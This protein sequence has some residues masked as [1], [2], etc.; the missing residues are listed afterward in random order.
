M[1]HLFAG[2]AIM[3]LMAAIALAQSELYE[4]IG[5]PLHAPLDYSRIEAEIEANIER[6]SLERPAAATPEELRAG[7]DR[8]I[9]PVRARP[10]AD[11]FRPSFIGNF[12]DL[13]PVAPFSRRDWACGART[14]DLNTGYDHAGTDISSGPF[15]AHAMNREWVEV[16]A[17]APGVIIARNDTAPDRN[18]AGLGAQQ[19]ANYVSIL[20]DD[21]LTAYYWHLA[22]ATVTDRQIGDRVEAGDFLG[23][24]GSSGISTA[25]HL[26]FELRHPDIPGF[27][28][29]PYEGICGQGETMW[30]HQH[31]YVD[32][33]ITA[34]FTHNYTPENVSDSFCQPEYPRFR[35][36]FG[37]GD[38]VYVGLYVRDRAIGAMSSLSVQDPSGTTVFTHDFPEAT[39]FAA[40]GDYQ[41]SFVLADDATPGQWVIR[42]E[43]GLD[44]RERAFYVGGSHV[45]EARLAAAL[46]PNSRS[47]QSGHA[48][49]VFATVLNP[50]EGLARGCWI[51]PASPFAGR[52]EYRETDPVTNAVTG[53]PNALFDI[54]GGGAR[55]FVLSF[56]PNTGSEANAYDLLLRYKC[57]NS[58][59]T[60]YLSGVNTVL[61]SFGDRPT[62]D[63][64]A[65]A[66]TPSRDGILR[67]PDTDSGNAFAVAVANVGAEGEL[68]VRPAG[69]REAGTLRLRICETDPDTGAC[70]AAAGDSITRVFAADESASFAVFARGGG[71]AVPFAPASNR[72]QLIAT[73]E[74]GVIRGSTS[75]AVRTD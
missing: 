29:D 57:D 60:A 26:H 10:N 70:L 68:M 50:S 1:V 45:A 65:I 67:L 74:N 54:A 41:T 69:L 66:L 31:N 3:P 64:V 7:F 6:L 42:A 32:P 38:R 39:T 28:V 56:T 13:D 49:T 72:I 75:V 25:P 55:S 43:Y 44:V 71:S 53:D 21:G 51:S 5:Q 8:L 59:S 52:F 35:T 34:I 24:V 61:L 36:D 63:L 27:V 12:V 58:D 11:L 2:A 62:P 15:R 17:A 16:V 18:C 40:A 19:S 46:L 47:V 20:Q 14:Y 9:F 33:V 48:A 23:F 22:R 30:R 37:P 73:D 4:P